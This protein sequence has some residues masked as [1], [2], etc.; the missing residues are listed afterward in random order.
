MQKTFLY[1]AKKL[2]GFV[3]TC[4]LKTFLYPAV[5]H[6]AIGA[7]RKTNCLDSAEN[8]D[9]LAAPASEE[10]DI[11]QERRELSV[12]LSTLTAEHREVLLLRFVDRLSL[13]EIAQ[14]LALPLGTVK[15]RLHHALGRL[16]MVCVASQVCGLNGQDAD[17]WRV[18]RQREG[19][20]DPVDIYVMSGADPL[21]AYQVEFVA[22]GSDAKIVGV[23]GGEHPAFADPPH[24]DPVALRRERV[25]LAAFSTEAVLPRGRIRVATVHLQY[26]GKVPQYSVKLSTAASVGGENISVEVQLQPRSKP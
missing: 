6:F 22:K 8:W 17:G 1:L 10:W 14:G 12:V 3:L 13:A 4:Q 16:L 21:A 19:Q 7:R 11:D 5:R 15:S 25:I 9:R 20:F 2:P 26:R 24:Y 23:E 18:T